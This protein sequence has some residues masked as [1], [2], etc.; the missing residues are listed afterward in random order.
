MGFFLVDFVRGLFSFIPSLLLLFHPDIIVKI[1]QPS[2]FGFGYF[3]LVLISL[4]FGFKNVSNFLIQYFY[5]A[6]S[7]DDILN[8]L[9]KTFIFII[10]IIIAIILYKPFITYFCKK[11]FGKI[12]GIVEEI[13]DIKYDKKNI[14]VDNDSDSS[15]FDSQIYNL[16]KGYSYAVL[17]TWYI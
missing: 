8:S 12:S 14:K 1:I 16:L 9:A 2:L 5:T 4:L 17:T 15:S 6:F 11:S 10:W 13:M 7:T 3:F